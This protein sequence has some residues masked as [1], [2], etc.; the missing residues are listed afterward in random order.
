MQQTL[1]SI[2]TPQTAAIILPAFLRVNVAPG[3]L[4]RASQQLGRASDRFCG[5]PISQAPEARHKLAQPVRAGK[6]PANTSSAVGA[7]QP[8]W[9]AALPNDPFP[10]S[11]EPQILF[12]VLLEIFHISTISE[13]STPKNL[14][15]VVD[16]FSPQSY[17]VFAKAFESSES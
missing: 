6:T 1:I 8:G 15:S 3:S 5:C 11:A 10:T 4:F 14:F 7:T 17:N 2:F 16:S 13:I 9:G 12:D